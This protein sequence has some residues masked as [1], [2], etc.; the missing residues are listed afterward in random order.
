VIS[1]VIFD[2]DGL[3]LDSEVYWERARGDYSASQ[4]CAWSADDELAVK[5]MNS[6]EWASHIRDRCRLRLDLEAIIAGVSDRMHSLYAGHLP[7]LPGAIESVRAC[8]TRYPLGLASSSPPELIE[9][10]LEDAGVRAAF[11]VIVSSDEVGKGKPNPDV[12]LITGERLRVNPSQIA[13]FEDSS[14]GIRA[15]YDAGMHVIAVPNPHFPPTDEALALAD[16]VMSSLTEFSLD[17][18]ESV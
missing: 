1:A 10:V 17:M 5:G 2:M 9:F 12:F 13:V 18:L 4:G 6:R 16:R 3:L 7:M 11:S 8:A 14:A 15:A